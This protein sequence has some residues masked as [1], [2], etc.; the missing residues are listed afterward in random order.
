M[1]NDDVT[2]DSQK[3]DKL[4]SNFSNNLDNVNKKVMDDL[5]E[6]ALSEMKKNY[7]AAEFQPGNSETMSFSIEDDES[8][9]IVKM[10]GPQAAYSEF[11]TGTQGELS[12]H[13]K[14]SEY[15]LNAYN[16]GKTIRPAQKD[17]ITDNFEF[18]S[19]GSLYW[20]YTGEDGQKHYTQGIP[21]QKEVFDAGQTVLKKM[22]SII[23]ERLGE[24]FKQ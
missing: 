1:A 23:K 8:G 20:T 18:I 16:S 7:S 17:I 12:P 9:K 15:P 5:S 2:I 14:K 3:L 21:A 24:M 4:L 22:N 6:L 13:P 19:A 10:S 11:G